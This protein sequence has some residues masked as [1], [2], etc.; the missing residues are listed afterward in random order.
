MCIVSILGVRNVAEADYIQ[1]D[2]TSATSS[3][4][5][6]Q[7]RPCHQTANETDSH[8]NFEVA[9]Q[10]IAIQGVVVEDIAVWDLA[11]S[12]EPIEHA[13]WKIWGP[14]SRET[15]VSLIRFVL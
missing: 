11:E 15:V 3:I 5:G 7:D 4:D 2:L 8:R 12:T 14:L 6:E 10:E 13:L 1:L 9:Q